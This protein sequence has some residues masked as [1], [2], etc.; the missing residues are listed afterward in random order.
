MIPAP[1]YLIADLRDR[2]LRVKLGHH[3]GARGVTDCRSRLDQDHNRL[4]AILAPSTMAA[5]FR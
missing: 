4:D 2:H 5:S 3:R 1:G